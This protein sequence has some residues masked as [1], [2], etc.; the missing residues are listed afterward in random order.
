MYNTLR[1]S[2]HHS[3]CG[4]FV[5]PCALLSFTTKYHIVQ[6]K[7]ILISA[8][9]WTQWSIYACLI[10]SM[11]LFSYD[12][13]GGKTF[14]LLNFLNSSNEVLHQLRRIN[15]GKMLFIFF[16]NP[17]HYKKRNH[18]IISNSLEIYIYQL[19]QNMWLSNFCHFLFIYIWLKKM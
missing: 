16:K 6:E 1:M 4:G 9:I 8:Y 18:F 11:Q 3:G 13:F 5:R 7:W 2:I 17:I 10:F 12:T 19:K 14:K 15:W